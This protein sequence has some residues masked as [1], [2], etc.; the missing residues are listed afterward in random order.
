MAGEPTT[1]EDKGGFM[2]EGQE[3]K[4][5]GRRF[6]GI[7]VPPDLKKSHFPNL[8]LATLCIA[9][10]MTVP[11]I[12]QPAFLK[13]VIGIPR[14]Q[15]GAINSGLQNM[16]Q[17]AMFCFVGLFGMLADRVG[18]RTLIIL[19]FAVSAIFYVLFG[20]AKD[21][22]L[23]LG[24]TSLEGQIFVTYVIRFI[25][26]VGAVLSF[27]QTIV[28]VADY[29][30]P[31]DRGKGMAYHGICMS[32]A[33]IIT[34][35]VLAQLAR[36]TGLMSIFYISGTIGLLGLIVTLLGLVD[37]MPKEKAKKRGVREVYN[38]VSK[39]LAVKVGYITTLVARADILVIA[40][41]LIVWMVYMA[42][43][44]GISP[45][46]ATARGGI[47]MLVMALVSLVTWPIIG[48]LLDR[49]GRVPVIITALISA[50]SGFCLIAATKNPFSPMVYLYVTM[51]GVGFAAASAGA[52]ALAADAAPKPLLASI[53]G[54]L[55]M[56]QPIGSLIFLQMG[57]FL[58]DW[59]G[60]WSAFALKGVAD[61]AL[62][63]W[64][65]AVRKS[66]VI[67]EE[68]GHPHG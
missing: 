52:N 21:I 53:I 44:A 28:M 11:A 48:I 12:L 68:E 63:L 24:I 50:G 35:G 19:G 6:A 40:T 38:V 4:Q 64:I 62:G 27:P 37:R 51:L 14:E 61:L 49:W 32:L 36:R 39:R 30:S 66:I 8:Y 13:E 45:I 43:K 33:S 56:M 47:V 20:H 3:G 17:V 67:P 10:L 1:A 16:S 25:I 31:R 65:F 22:S 58:F 18:R 5:A 26:G 7:E 23:A 55:H 34:F 9:C 41:F 57:G 59:L 29:T 15:A 42:D 2:S 46:K 60:P 54:A